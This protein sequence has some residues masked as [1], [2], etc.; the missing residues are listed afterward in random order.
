[1]PFLIALLV[2]S[3]DD[4]REIAIPPDAEGRD[5]IFRPLGRVV[6]KKR[7]RIGGEIVGERLFYKDGQLADERL[8]RNKKLHGIWR[9]FHPNGELF[10]ERP[11]RDGQ[12]DGTFRFW[13]EN[14]KLF[15][16]SV[17]KNGSG[18]LREFGKAELQSDDAETQYVGGKIHGRQTRW[19]R[20]QGCSGLGYSTSEYK[21][22]VLDGWV[23]T[24]DEDGTLI[25]Y[26]HCRLDQLHGVFRRYE[27]DG[28][29]REGFPKY[30]IN[31]DEVSEARFLD[32]AKTDK[33]LG[34]TLTY[35]PPRTEKPP[36]HDKPPKETPENR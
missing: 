2:F 28:N 25:G 22:G 9:Q 31:G 3:A 13:D 4:L 14:G 33:L 34:E 12:M 8:Y 16:E 21:R 27:R 29:P 24:R 36:L 11:Y 32:S 23:I 20:F 18:V 5:A 30:Y 6:S 19:G 7:Y 35:A 26:S 1:V 17:M 10:A 15:A